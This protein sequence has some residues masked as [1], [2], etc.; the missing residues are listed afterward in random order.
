MHRACHGE[1]EGEERDAYCKR[2]GKNGTYEMV[3]AVDGC[4]P[5]TFAIRYFLH[6]TVDDDDGVVNYHSKR[7]YQCCQR[8]RVQLDAKRV[9]QS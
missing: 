2:C 4:V 7:Y 8:N 6:I 1:K 3:G 9:E 5:A